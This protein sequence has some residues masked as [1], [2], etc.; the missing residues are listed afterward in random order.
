MN[1]KSILFVRPDYHCTFFYRDEFRRLGWKADVFVNPGYPNGLL[2]SQEDILRPPHLR[3][4]RLWPVR[5]INRT[6]LL[7]WYLSFFWRYQYHFY[8]WRPPA[9]I[10]GLR[11]LNRIFG[12]DFLAELSIAKFFG[13]KLIFLPSGCHDDESK[14]VFSQFDA[15]AVCGN[16]GAWNRCDDRLNQL[17]FGRVRRYFDLKI[18]VGAIDSSQFE[19]THIKYKAIDLDLWSPS[20]VVPEEHRLPTSE[21]IRILHSSH[22][23]GA[24]DWGGRNIKGSP[25]VAAAVDRLIAEGYPVEFLVV[26]GLPSN[27]MRFY[28]A[29]ADIVVDQLIY[30]WWGSTFVEAAS[31]GKPVVCYLRSSWKAFFLERFPEYS[32]L[33]VVEADVSSIYDA[34][35]TLVS[36]PGFRRQKGEQ[37]RQFAE[38]HFNPALNTRALV[39]L[40]E[41]L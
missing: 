14:E 38:A 40:L 21:K 30:G 6:I 15:G 3:G 2:Y 11:V 10:F 37:S 24:R 36:D 7:L 29:Q 1:R 33:P 4:E 35:K 41:R 17:N 25:F 39:D 27:R 16:C 18:G 20:L 8:Y 5:W 34:L 9:F 19:M 26:D 31:L 13:I 22:L 28:Q 23:K 32:C 12:E